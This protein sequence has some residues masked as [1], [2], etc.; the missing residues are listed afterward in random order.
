MTHPVRPPAGQR[1]DDAFHWRALRGLAP[2]LWP[3]AAPR[4]RARVVL[5]LGLLASAKCA[6]VYVPLLYRRMV[7]MFADPTRLPLELPLALMFSYGCLRVMQI[8]FAEL[9]DAVF[10]KVAQGAI[11]DVAFST[12]RHLHGLALRFHLDR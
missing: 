12:F 8:V 7:D 3:A 1:H 4:T 10:A 2:Y 5:A 6:T 9:R 11:R